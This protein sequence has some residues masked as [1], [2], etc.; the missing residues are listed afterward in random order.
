MT[1]K[2]K[3][4]IKEGMVDLPREIQE[5][6]GTFSWGG[7]VEEIGK[8]YSLSEDE[9]ND[10]QTETGLVLIGLEY[11][12][13]FASNIE[14]EVGT[15][16]EEAQKIAEEIDQKVFKSI[17]ES[18]SNKIKLGL[19]NKNPKW[20]QNIDFVLSNGDYTAFLDADETK[21]IEENIPAVIPPKID[22][23]FINKKNDL[24]SQFKI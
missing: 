19:K 1:E 14:T 13:A 6:I 22:I 9:V 2:L 23:G 4:K 24:G 20:N 15:S 5:A 18:L 7:V 11:G 10:L 17:Y 3:Q 12:N 16:H 8:K 21:K